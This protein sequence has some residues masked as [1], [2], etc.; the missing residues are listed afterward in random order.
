LSKLQFN[1]STIQDGKLEA[2]TVVLLFDPGDPTIIKG[3]TLLIVPQFIASNSYQV[4][5]GSLH[6]NDATPYSGDYT[7]RF[8]TSP[9]GNTWIANVVLDVLADG[10]VD[11]RGVSAGLWPAGFHVLDTAYTLEGTGRVKTKK[12]QVGDPGTSP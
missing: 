8:V 7:L 6:A 5:S 4:V 2:S 1:A 3:G 10:T 11:L 9:V 12:G